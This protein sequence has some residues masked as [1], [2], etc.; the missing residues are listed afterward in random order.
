[1]SAGDQHHEEADALFRDAVR[2]RILLLTTNLV[3][4]EVHRFLLFR[5]GVKAAALALARIAASPLLRLVCAD[6]DHDRAA[7]TWLARLPDQVITYTDAV[8]FAV[9]EST[10][11]AVVISFDHDFVVAGFQLMNPIAGPRH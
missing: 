6:P 9:M 2:M 4:A 5:G 10:R 1:M 7:R 3:V 11:C 8:S